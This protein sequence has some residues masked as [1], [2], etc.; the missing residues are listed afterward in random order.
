MK[1]SSGRS[2][3][4][5]LHGAAPAPNQ[6]HDQRH[7]QQHQEYE[8]KDLRDAG[9]SG[10]NSAEAEDT[11]DDRHD[12]E[13]KSPVK[14]DRPPES[15]AAWRQPRGDNAGYRGNAPSAGRVPIED[16]PPDGRRSSSRSP[17]AG[18]G[19]ARRWAR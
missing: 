18:S 17:A 15:F 8:E 7:H 16:T 13:H 5:T 9:G 1:L 3:Q 6:V 4:G 12:E 19:E 11:G 14:H 10:S 2:T